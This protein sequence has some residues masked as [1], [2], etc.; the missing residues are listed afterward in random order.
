M[1]QQRIILTGGGTA[2]HVT[3]N[4]ALVPLLIQQGWQVHYIG[5][6]EGIE[7]GL[8][9]AHPGMTYHPIHAGKLRRYFDLKNVTDIFRTIAG[10]G[11]AVKVIHK[12]KPAVVFSKGGFV[13]VPVLAAAW[14]LRIPT[15]SHES[16]MTPGLATRLSMRFA[17]TVCVTFPETLGHTGKKGKLTGTPLRQSLYQGNAARGRAACGFT[18]TLPALLVMGGSQGATAINDALRASIGKLLPRFNV[19]HLCGKGNL[20]TALEGKQGY[21]QMEYATDTMADLL[22]AADVVV[23]RAGANSLVE[24]QALAKPMLLIPLPRSASRGDQLQN[25]A[26]YQKRGLAH[27]ME[28]E[29]MTPDTLCTAIFHLYDSRTQLKTAMQNAQGADGTQ[30]VLQTILAASQK[31][32]K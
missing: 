30:A 18:N 2:G 20:D 1:T 19:I 16:D 27:V 9:Q 15:V 32:R 25:A 10:V 12:V 11:E 21:C 22:A 29:K 31:G 7:R 28:Q 13:S 14:L 23:T 6:H 4:L 24:L 8:V 5:T 17:G 3:P 26:S